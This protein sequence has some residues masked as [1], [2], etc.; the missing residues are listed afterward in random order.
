[1]S[2]V[3]DAAVQ[4]RYGQLQQTLQKTPTLPILTALVQY[5]PELL[6][7]DVSSDDSSRR[8]GK[9][10]AAEGETAH[11][12]E[13]LETVH[14]VYA[15]L[16]PSLSGSTITDQLLASL[17]SWLSHTTSFIESVDT[18]DNV[19][20]SSWIS[21]ASLLT[22]TL[23]SFIKADKN[24]A[25]KLHT[26]I[27]SHTN[28]SKA[29]MA[30]QTM[31]T[32][33]PASA[34]LSA[35]VRQIFSVSLFSY[36][37]LSRTLQ[38]ALL[39]SSTLE[40]LSST[41]LL[42]EISAAVAANVATAGN[43]VLLLLPLLTDELDK[44]L[45][46]YGLD[47]L[48]KN[49]RTN[50]APM[51]TSAAET[52]ALTFR[53]NATFSFLSMTLD[54]IV[55]LA[56][57]VDAARLVLHLVNHIEQKKLYTA[58]AGENSKSWM[59]VLCKTVQY[60]VDLY[61]ASRSTEAVEAMTTVARLDFSAVE[62]AL[63]DIMRAVS[64]DRHSSIGESFMQEAISYAARLR[65]LPTLVGQIAD[66][67][68]SPLADQK[69]PS[70][71]SSIISLP[72]RQLLAK[73]CVDSLS[74][75]QA[76]SLVITLLERMQQIITNGF[77]Q[78]ET[79]GFE[80]EQSPKKRK[81]GKDSHIASLD[82]G[83]ENGDE[84]AVGLSKPAGSAVYFQALASLAI[85][86]LQAEIEVSEHQTETVCTAVNELC[87]IG[88]SILLSIHTASDN[89]QI[90]AAACLQLALACRN[91]GKINLP[92][93]TQLNAALNEVLPATKRKKT[94]SKTILP[95]LT[96]QIVCVFLTLDLSVRC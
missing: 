39:P 27:L 35:A 64:T 30:L 74:A 26:F 5:V 10:K 56:A 53:R 59:N 88:L 37:N 73:E 13:L 66:A 7:E 92:P 20:C 41:Q 15:M 70:L 43:N 61:V 55:P 60:L 42:R 58:A 11:V 23:Q 87:N 77:G 89:Q 40:Q 82:V 44:A 83:V 32:S 2:L 21:I 34:Q 4:T 50:A 68:S 78:R 81:T 76:M 71:R 14:Q 8:K 38:P 9:A 12:V 48:Q 93:I 29:V 57:S 95:C 31:E 86:I 75:D 65:N 19:A 62:P 36:Q 25:R 90:Q 28:F 91:F 18:S 80:A 17:S 24:A 46:K 33:S 1:M 79:G 63:P 51:S 49:V 67:F 6:K 84:S 16:L 52:T 54:V 96:V 45:Q 47:L 72:T 85:V 3:Q 94:S 22:T 69:L